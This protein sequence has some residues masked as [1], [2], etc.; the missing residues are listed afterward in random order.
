[1]KAK[2][3][4]ENDEMRISTQKQIVYTKIN[5]RDFFQEGE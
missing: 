2:C 1:M 5:R 4:A 3:S